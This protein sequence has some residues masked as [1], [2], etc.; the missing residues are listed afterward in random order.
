MKVR[1]VNNRGE[2]LRQ[3]EYKS[4]EKNM[5]G[6][7]GATGHSE[8]N[9]ITLGREYLVMGIIIFETYQAYL[10]D[11]DGDISACPCLLFEIIDNKINFNWNFRLVEKNENIYPFIQSILGYPE[12]CSD[13]K[14]YE[15]LIVE[16][17]KETAKIYFS[18][19]AELEKDILEDY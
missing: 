1:C 11:D 14:A 18:R 2:F 17:D 16:G 4:L 8:Y 9:E 15:N 6:R 10:I 12:L 13:K 5:M 3:F 19:K 7:F